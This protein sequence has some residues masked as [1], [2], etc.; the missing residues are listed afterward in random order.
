M[1]EFLLVVGLLVAALGIGNFVF[2]DHGWGEVASI[3][4]AVLGSGLLIT[5]GVRT[6]KKQRN[7]NGK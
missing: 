5:Y 2:P 1:R 6:A 4:C 7:K 3:V